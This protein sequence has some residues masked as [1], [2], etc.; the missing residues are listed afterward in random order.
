MAAVS[1]VDVVAAAA[2]AVVSVV[3]A[4][5]AAAVVDS[6]PRDGES[7]ST[8]HS[9]RQ[10]ALRYCTS[11]RY[12]NLTNVPLHI[13]TDLKSNEVQQVTYK[14]FNYYWS[15]AGHIVHNSVRRIECI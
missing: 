6:V 4:V 12:Q 3:V 14:R 1:V 2:V 13:R 15:F 11:K 10:I 7:T 5:A 8:N 9:P